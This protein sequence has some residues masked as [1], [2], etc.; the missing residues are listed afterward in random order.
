MT[1]TKTKKPQPKK[2]TRAELSAD[3]E[4]EVY[5]ANVEKVRKLLV[6]HKAE[7]LS[8]MLLSGAEDYKAVN[9]MMNS[10]NGRK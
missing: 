7:D 8:D 6:K 5:L 10:L 3:K 9:E 1:K 4:K 2:K